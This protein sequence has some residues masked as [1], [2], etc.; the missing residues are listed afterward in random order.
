MI[1]MCRAVPTY[2]LCSS[3]SSPFLS[4]MTVNSWLQSMMVAEVVMDH[5]A[6][7]VGKPSTEIRDLNMYREGDTTH[8]GQVLDG[9]QVTNVCFCF[10]TSDPIALHLHMLRIKASG[11]DPSAGASRGYLTCLSLRWGLSSTQC[12]TCSQCLRPARTWGMQLIQGHQA[13]GV[14]VQACVWLR[15]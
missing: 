8:Y 4:L 12:S 15:L 10:C 2:E 5:I 11:A 3:S 13:C 1:T 7:A 6:R 14:C 9:C